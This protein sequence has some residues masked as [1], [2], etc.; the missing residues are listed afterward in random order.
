MRSTDVLYNG[1]RWR[2]SGPAR[3]LEQSL[4]AQF[5]EAVTPQRGLA[6]SNL[7][8]FAIC[9]FFNPSAAGKINAAPQ[10]HTGSY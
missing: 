4:D 9:L 8:P 3:I 10:R 2:V 5:V 7:Q 6:Q 1:D